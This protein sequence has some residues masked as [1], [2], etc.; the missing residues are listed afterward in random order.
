MRLSDEVT[1]NEFKYVSAWL[2][3]RMG[4]VKVSSVVGTLR[5]VR[6]NERQFTRGAV[7]IGKTGRGDAAMACAVAVRA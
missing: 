4:G 2:A 7:V 5:A 6:S 3:D 1:A